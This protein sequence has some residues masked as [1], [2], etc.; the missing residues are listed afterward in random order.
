MRGLTHTMKN[1]HIHIPSRRDA[2]EWAET[3]LHSDKTVD[4]ALV[5]MA[6]MLCGWLVY[7]LANAFRNSAYL[8]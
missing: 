1:T 4:A 6:V 7:C 2:K 8:V 3:V 5:V